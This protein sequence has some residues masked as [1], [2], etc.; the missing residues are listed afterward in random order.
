MKNTLKNA[1][2]FWNNQFRI[3]RTSSIDLLD[4]PEV[5]FKYVEYLK[6]EDILTEI[7]LLEKKLNRLIDEVF[8]NKANIVGII[9]HPKTWN[10]IYDSYLLSQYALDKVCKQISKNTYSGIK[11]IKSLDIKENEFKIL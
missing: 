2:E 4:M 8:Y 11:I 6:E 5:L 7:F 1:E 9:L 10:K 3:F